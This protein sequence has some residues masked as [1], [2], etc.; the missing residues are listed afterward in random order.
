M[1][2]ITPDI[3]EYIEH[4][5]NRKKGKRRNILKTQQANRKLLEKVENHRTD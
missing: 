4:I 3:W 1:G 2:N 5:Q